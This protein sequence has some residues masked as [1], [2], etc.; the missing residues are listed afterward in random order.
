MVKVRVNGG[1]NN[2]GMFV[3]LPGFGGEK[4]VTGNHLFRV[5]DVVE[6]FLRPFQPFPF[7]IGGARIGKPD[8]VIKV[9]NN[10]CS[11]NE[12]AFFKK[13]ASKKTRFPLNKD[14]VEILQPAQIL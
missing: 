1:R 10:V 3:V 11:G 6:K 7:N 12:R 14:N 2:Q 13:T 4:I 9:E 8:A 5:R